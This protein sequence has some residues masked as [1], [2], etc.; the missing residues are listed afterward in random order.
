MG[1]LKSAEAATESAKLSDFLAFFG[2][3]VAGFSFWNAVRQ[4][5]RAQTW[6]RKEFMAAQMAAFAA[7][8]AVQQ[9][10]KILDYKARELNLSGD[11]TEQELHRIRVDQ[12]VAARALV[13]DKFIIEN[14]SNVEFSIRDGFDVFLERI[15][16]FHDMVKAKLL[17]L[18]DIKPY[19]KYWLESIAD[20]DSFLDPSLRRS[21]WL[22]IDEYEYHG[23]QELCRKIGYKKII[24]SRKDKAALMEDIVALKV[25]IVDGKSARER[26][27]VDKSPLEEGQG[28]SISRG[29][30][31]AV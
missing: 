18:D 12:R 19:L 8:P 30:P 21:L 11:E 31:T 15:D 6:K 3:C 16:K 26:S 23:V 17:K 13:P 4:A 28:A 24:P 25:E 5:K 2:I 7:D 27:G 1:V 22:F 9:T 29:Q 14:F 20:T 10:L